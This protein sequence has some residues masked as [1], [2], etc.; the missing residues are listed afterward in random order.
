M[1]T[2]TSKEQIGDH[3][4]IDGD[5]SLRAVVTGVLFREGERYL[6]E[7]SWIAGGKNEVA[8]IESYRCR[9]VVRHR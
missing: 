5:D 9:L 2:F 8:L 1:R 4:S 6:L 7:L 3:V